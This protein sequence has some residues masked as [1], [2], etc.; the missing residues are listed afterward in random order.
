[1]DTVACLQALL[2]SP[3]AQA[4]TWVR[5]Q[6]RIDVLASVDA[7]GPLLR[8]VLPVGRP[9]CSHDLQLASDLLR[10]NAEHLDAGGPCFSLDER[11]GA[12]CL[13]AALALPGLAPETAAAAL[14]RLATTADEARAWLAEAILFFD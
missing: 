7:C 2:A 5:L 12:I 8:L 10:W 6:G 14:E 4:S 3:H 9:R 11:D 1:M 13:G